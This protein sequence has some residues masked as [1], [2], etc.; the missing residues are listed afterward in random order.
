MK[1]EVGEGFPG[2]VYF[3]ARM[4]DLTRNLY[5]KNVHAGAQATYVDICSG[6]ALIGFD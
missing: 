2:I 1:A 3:K 5:I 4:P 6:T